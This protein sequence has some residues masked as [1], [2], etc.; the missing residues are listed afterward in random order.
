MF[1]AELVEIAETSSGR[2]IVLVWNR[3]WKAMGRIESVKRIPY[4]VPY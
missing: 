3:R 2:T 1:R 4:C